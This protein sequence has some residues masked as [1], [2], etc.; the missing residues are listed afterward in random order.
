MRYF[1]GLNRT[2]TDFSINKL[3]QS[4]F[5]SIIKQKVRLHF[6]MDFFLECKTQNLTL[7]ILYDLIFLAL[8]SPYV[9]LRPCDVEV[10]S[11]EIFIFLTQMSQY[12]FLD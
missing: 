9:Y 3:M 12:L 6:I 4:V 10:L 5:Y 7:D 2:E 1:L 11:S 8:D